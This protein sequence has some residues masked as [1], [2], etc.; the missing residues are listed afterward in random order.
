MS[1]PL[2]LNEWIIHD[3]EG[4]N[5]SERQNETYE[6]L[7]Q[8]E[9]KCDHLVLLRGSMWMKK[10]CELMKESGKSSNLRILSKFLFNTFILNP[11][12][13]KIFESNEVPPLSADLESVISTDDLYLIALHILLPGSIVVTTDTKLME[14]LSKSPN[15]IIKLRDD[16]LKSYT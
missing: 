8:V 3:L 7:N 6:F 16:F 9:R 13:C 10:A 4:E 1:T 11:V 15:I 12:K 14:A 2:V 5:G